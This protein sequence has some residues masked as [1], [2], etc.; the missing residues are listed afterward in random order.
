MSS[1]KEEFV[2]SGTQDQG[3]KYLNLQ[4]HGTNSGNIPLCK[5]MQ[6]EWGFIPFMTRGAFLS[7]D[8]YEKKT[9]SNWGWKGKLLQNTLRDCLVS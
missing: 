3:K 5:F 2:R 9:C 8:T 7:H 4:T 1:F 6:M